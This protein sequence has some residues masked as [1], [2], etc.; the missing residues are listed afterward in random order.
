MN[1]AQI[2]QRACKIGASGK[3]WGGTAQLLKNINRMVFSCDISYKVRIGKN[4]RLLHQGLGVVIGPGVVIG[5]NVLIAQNVTLGGK[6]NGKGYDVPVIGDNVMIGAG[7]KIL[8]GVHIGSNV[9][10]GAN[11]VVLTDIP[12]NVMAAG[13]PAKVV[14]KIDGDMQI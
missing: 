10:I 7:A 14:K 1:A 9:Q 12:N 4:L 3:F 8:G 13:I 6:Q 5:D 11:A 2:A